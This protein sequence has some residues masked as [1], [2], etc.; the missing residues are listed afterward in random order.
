MSHLWP[1]ELPESVKPPCLR[2]TKIERNPDE[3]K[4]T[5]HRSTFQI[6]GDCRVQRQDRPSL[7]RR[8]GLVK[9]RSSKKDRQAWRFHG[10]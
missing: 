7:F 10:C 1:L 9:P 3:V 5:T 4:K 6:E 2:P 8:F